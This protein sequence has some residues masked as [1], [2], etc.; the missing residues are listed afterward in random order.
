M[1]Q[2]ST[3]QGNPNDINPYAY[4]PDQK[5]PGDAL[6]KLGGLGSLAQAS[7][8]QQLKSAR[9]TLIAIGILTV[10]VNLV[11]MALL[12]D[13]VKKALQ[14]NGQGQNQ[15]ALNVAMGVAMAIQGSFLVLGIV[16]II[17][18]VL[19]KQFPVACTVSA[20]VL[21]ILA[22]LATAA[23]EPSTL[24]RGIVIKIIIVVALFKA[25]Q[26]AF[27]YQKEMQT[28]GA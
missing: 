15:Q 9:T 21:Y 18:G 4:T 10:I 27:A 25:V 1:S 2:P 13:Q 23:L 5:I 11:M 7:R 6:P 28:S 20:L 16:F 12:P 26:A 22:A 8:G 3:S 19:V 14:E 17:C 24:A